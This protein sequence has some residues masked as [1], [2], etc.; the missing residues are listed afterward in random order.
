MLSLPLRYRE[1]VVLLRPAGDVIRGRGLGA[2]VPDRHGP[3]AAAIAAAALLTAK[4]LAEQQAREQPVEARLNDH[5]VHGMNEQQQRTL[6]AG[7]NARSPTRHARRVG[8][9]RGGRLAEMARITRAGPRTPSPRGETLR[10]AAIA[11][12]PLI[13][14]G[15]AS[16][17]CTRP[18]A[19]SSRPQLHPAGFVA[20]PAAAGLPPMESGAIVRVG[21]PFPRCRRTGSR[22]C[23]KC[24][25]DSVDAD[26]LVAQ[27]GLTRAHP[28][29]QRLD[30]SRSTP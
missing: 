30:N 17:S 4:M 14:S 12:S 13:A 24:S 22:S 23:P 28:T 26:L 16:G 9:P 20:I 3:L 15:A 1:V 10:L 11:A 25:T 21:C 8:K 2:R 6:I 7:L 29:R 18:A 27:D 19:R 5:E